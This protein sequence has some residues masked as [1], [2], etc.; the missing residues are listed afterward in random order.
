[1]PRSDPARAGELFATLRPDLRRQTR[2]AGG[3]E[4][5]ATSASRSSDSSRRVRS[6]EERS[7]G[8]YPS[9]YGLPGPQ[10]ARIVP[11]RERPIS[12]QVMQAVDGPST[13]AADGPTYEEVLREETVVGG[14]RAHGGEERAAS[15]DE[16]PDYAYFDALLAK[17]PAPRP[18]RSNA[19]R[20]L[21]RTWPRPPGSPRSLRSRSAARCRSRS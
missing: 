12:G 7:R 20:C 18:R 13:R 15:E 10:T 3:T 14:A 4:T 16:P 1:M 21:M 19:L 6:S 2:G 11:G 8:R 9:T 17:L 5:G